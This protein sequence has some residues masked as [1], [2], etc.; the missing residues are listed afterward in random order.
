M[1]LCF[2]PASLHLVAA[3]VQ[4]YP[5]GGHVKFS[6]YLAPMICCLIGVGMAQI[7]V[8]GSRRTFA[9]KQ[10]FAW[11]CAFFFVVG[12]G[13]VIRDLAYPYKT[14]SDFRARAFAESFWPGT[15]SVEE[16]ACLKSDLGLDFVPKQHVELSWSAHYRCNR[17]IEV[18]RSS[19]RPADLSR[20]SANRPVRYVLYR[21]ARYELDRER[22]DSWLADMQLQ[23]DLIAHE[24]LPF[25]RFAKNDRKLLTMEYI[26]SYK[27]VPRDAS[28]KDASPLAA[29][30]DTTKRQ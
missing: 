20:V 29:E 8:W 17:A 22:L 27:F 23:Y 16:V 21:D 7:I 26:D 3:A 25:P 18:S 9:A 14:R 4:K 24:S 6:Q 19:L 2:G 13:G 12:V 28:A 15:H 10:S 30:P 1:G 5:Y 11:G